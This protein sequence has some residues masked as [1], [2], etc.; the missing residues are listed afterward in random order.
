MSVKQFIKTDRHEPTLQEEIGALGD[1]PMDFMNLTQNETGIAGTLFVSTAMGPHGPRVK[2]FV[3]TGKGQPS[4]SVSI[5]VE[6]EVVA[7]SL[8]ERITSEM[9]PA[10][11][12]WIKLNRTALLNFWNEGQYWSRSEVNAFADS[13]Q[14]LPRA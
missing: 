3:R 1:D 2:Y 5:S 12:A 4:F 6:P 14:K 10:V 9:A 13:L 11:I 8:S 7:T